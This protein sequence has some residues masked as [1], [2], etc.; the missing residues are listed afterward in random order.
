[1][2][3]AKVIFPE[4]NL[5]LKKRALCAKANSTIN[6]VWQRL[7]EHLRG[8]KR[9]RVAKKNFSQQIRFAEKK[10]GGGK[11]FPNIFLSRAIFRVA[12]LNY[13]VRRA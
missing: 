11:K 8:I 3:A 13:D 10:G 12:L 4:R 2:K 6:T 5:S 1:M 7:R 9:G